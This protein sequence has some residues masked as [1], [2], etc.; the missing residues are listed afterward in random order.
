MRYRR[1]SYLAAFTGGILFLLTACGTSPV[2][3]KNVTN[4]TGNSQL[5]QSVSVSGS[6]GSLQKAM[7]TQIIPL[8]EK[9][10][11]VK[12][13]YTAAT[14][15]QSLAQV[16]A[17]K[18][19]PPYD[20]VWG[21]DG[22]HVQGASAGLWKTLDPK[23]VT[24]LADVYPEYLEPNN[25]GARF[26]FFVVGIEYNSE[27]FSKKGFSAPTSWQDLWNPSYKG[28]VGAYAWGVSFSAAMFG[29]LEKSQGGS[30]TKTFA[31]LARIKP[32]LL[33]VF[34]DSGSLD[35]SFSQGDT[36][37]AYNSNAR[38]LALNRSGVPV[39]FA[40]PKEGA[41]FVGNTMDIPIHAAHPN[42]AQAFINFMLSNEVQRLLPT[43]LAY[44]PVVKNA[45]IPSELAKFIPS[46]EQG[47]TLPFLDWN[48]I[49]K[50]NEQ[51]SQQWAQTLGGK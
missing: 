37:I 31:D 10:T 21:A 17:N 8:F 27:V 3:P 4:S 51:L 5:E 39:T 36:W 23:V 40:S 25:V 46:P 35:A 38:T 22:S 28:H 45:N 43:A 33:N 18:N 50:R 1:F 48:A 19:N 9:Q 42:A 41:T 13:T 30:E 34:Q 32:N 26:G 14:S 24:N 7:E 49:S 15:G 29:S 12:V 47:R 16:Q 2:S 6:G 11:G 20:V 44:S